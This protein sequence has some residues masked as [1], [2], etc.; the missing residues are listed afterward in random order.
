MESKRGSQRRR[1]ENVLRE[2]EIESL[3]REAETVNLEAS[4]GVIWKLLKSK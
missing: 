4:L 3:L 1:A 2:R